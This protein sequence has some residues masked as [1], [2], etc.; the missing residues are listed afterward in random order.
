MTSAPAIIPPKSAAAPGSFPF[1]QIEPTRRNGNG[2]GGGVGGVTVL[3][4]RRDSIY[5]TFPGVDVWDADRDALQW[6]GGTSVVA[7]PPCRAW[8]R[9]K[10]FA[11]PREGERELALWA[12]E[13]VRK[14][15]GVLEHPAASKLWPVAGLPEPGER[16]AWGG[17][18]L[19][20]VQMWWG[21]RAEKKTRLYICGVEPRDVPPTP[22]RLGEAP[23]IVGTPGRRRGGA[24]LRPGDSG[25]R[26]EVS[27]SEREHTPKL[28][29]TWLLEVAGRAAGA[30]V[31]R[32]APT[33]E[34]EMNIVLSNPESP[35]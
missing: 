10:H 34:K 8:G 12:V 6:P 28:L 22:I 31:G 15:G 23:C 3:F 26:P 19:P 30:G 13:Q 1:V 20:I 21:H 24:R 16:D 2:A 5:K 18:T 32:Y 33:T 17:W 29:A 27:K 11:R 14:W 25:Y 9:L 7:H 35:K 4:A